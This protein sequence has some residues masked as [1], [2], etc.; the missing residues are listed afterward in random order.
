[1][2]NT[3]MIPI[4]Y[5]DKFEKKIEKL[6]KKAKQ[7]NVDS[8]K[9][10]NLGVEI[11]LRYEDQYE[12]PCYKIKISQGQ[13]IKIDGYEFVGKL[14][15]NLGDTFLYNGDENVPKAQKEVRV[16]QH[17]NSNRARKLLYILKNSK[18]EYITVGKSC[19]IDYIGHSE[20]EKVAKYYQELSLF[21][22]LDDMFLDGY[23]IGSVEPTLFSIDQILRTSIVSIK[24]RGYYKS[25]VE[26]NMP[27]KVDVYNIMFPKLKR[28]KELNEEA[29]LI[30]KK[31]I[32]EIKEVIL[33]MELTS[34][35]IENLHAIIKDGYVPYKFLGYA[36]SIVPTAN[37]ELERIRLEKERIANEGNSSYVGVVGEKIE[38][39]A[40]FKRHSFYDYISN[41]TG[42]YETMHI[43]TF[44]DEN[45]NNIVWKTGP[46]KD[47]EIGD[48]LIIKGKVKEHSEYK[49]VKQTILTRPTI[50]FTDGNYK[51]K[52]LK[53][54]GEDLEIEVVCV[55]SDKIEIADG[56]F[57][58]EYEFLD[59]K[60]N[61]VVYK[62]DNSTGI[63]LD[64]KIL[65]K[66]KVSDYSTHKGTKK[67][68]LTNIEWSNIK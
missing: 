36:S 15:R 58:Y 62:S 47:F 59:K 28:E 3:F 32:D 5:M 34:N 27:T 7:L 50:K 43:Y 11:E 29:R 31:D 67:T 61:C 55:K 38:V 49:D 39:K 33:S 51:S 6:N 14:E 16:C 64:D 4:A 53:E 35:Y 45:G 8:I 52:F 30:P 46:N 40:V 26:D 2:E 42:Q 25:D 12:V 22:A 41:Y 9:V 65:L 66:G 57:K 37:K 54:K 19:L 48:R 1:M 56:D 10:E 63:K 18:D 24:D 44:V 13:D 68:V 20:A 23:G 60:K 21:F 17:C